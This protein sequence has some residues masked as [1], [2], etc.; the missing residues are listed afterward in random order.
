MLTNRIRNKR[1]LER[2]VSKEQA[3]TWISHGMTIG[4]SGFTSS[5]DAKTMPEA[6]AERAKVMREPFN[7]NVY[8]GASVSPA[9]DALLSAAGVVHKRLPFQSDPTMRSSINMGK[10]QYIDQHLSDTADQIRTLALP[11]VD[12]AI[13][14]AL[15]VTEEGYIVPTTSCGNTPIFIQ[16]AKE[17]I[18]EINLAQPLSLEGLHDIYDPGMPGNRPPIPLIKADQRIGTT[19]IKT[20]PGKIR[21]IVITHCPDTPKNLIQPDE[22]TKA[23]ASHLL[24]FLRQEMRKGTLPCPLPPLQSGVGS[25]ANAVFHGFMQAEFTDLQIYSEVLQ[26]SVFDLLDAGKVKSA[27]GGALTLSAEKME[28]VLANMDHYRDKVILRPQEMTNNPEL[29]R[30]LG[31]IAINTALEVDVY[32]NV[33]STH[34]L[35]SKMMNGIGGAGDFTRNARISIFVTK[36][37]AR[38]G[39]ISSIVPFASHVDHTEHDVAVV[40]TENGVADLRGLAPRERALSLIYQCAHPVYRE[41]LLSY[42]T[43]ACQRG[44]HTPHVLEKALSWHSHYREYDTMLMTAPTDTVHEATP[45]S[46]LNQ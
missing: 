37:T 24:A 4:F 29:I 32:G 25:V 34:I 5:G 23:I 33:N 31:L 9:I 11:Q 15:C 10:V 1:L 21:G 16:N 18:V 30:R 39:R 6:I 45:H 14:E 27:S 44:G 26:D 3:A 22:D 7:I 17:I 8:T 20:N 38:D 28:H 12:I 35:G 43:E 46:L 13:V 41:Q 40:I 19:Y 36:S 2:I 42:F